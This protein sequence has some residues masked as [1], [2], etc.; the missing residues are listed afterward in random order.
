[1]A[2][3]TKLQAVARALP[4]SGEKWAGFGMPVILVASPIAGAGCTTLAAHLAVE[5]GRTGTGP[6]LLLETA[7]AG[8]LSAW[9]SQRPTPAPEVQIIDTVVRPPRLKELEECGY[10]LC[11]IDATSHDPATLVQIANVADLVL[12]PCTL[13]REALDSIAEFAK[14][15]RDAEGRANVVITRATPGDQY[16][17][18]VTHKLKSEGLLCPAILHWDDR[19]GPA[20]AKGMTAGESKGKYREDSDIGQLWKA[21]IPALPQPARRPRWVKAWGKPTGTIRTDMKTVLVVGGDPILTTHLAVQAIRSGLGS[22]NVLLVGRKTTSSWSYW[23]QA[24]ETNVPPV[25]IIDDRGLTE[26]IVQ[27]GMA[28]IQLCIAEVDIDDLEQLPPGDGPVN[29]IVVPVP[30]MSFPDKSEFKRYEELASRPDTVFVLP[31]GDHK[32]LTR[33]ISEA[34][35]ASGGRIAGKVQFD[36]IDLQAWVE[37][38]TVMESNPESRAARQF[39]ELW[40]AIRQILYQV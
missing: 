31:E 36:V 29:L 37:G 24:R 33:D 39:V 30:P 22:Q 6:V 14:K 16:W 26:A 15:M 32:Q 38:M 18:D 10:G 17:N 1:M 9:V 40:A 20:M 11:I 23:E 2:L 12:I 35:R 34:L 19:I 4:D 25:K 27:A 5:A 3:V 7:P 8:G 28:G 21:V 13:A